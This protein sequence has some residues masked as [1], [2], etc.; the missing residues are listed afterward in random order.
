M[1]LPIYRI[2][3]LKNDITDD[4]LPFYSF[5]SSIEKV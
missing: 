5:I 3:S 4:S 1:V 2:P